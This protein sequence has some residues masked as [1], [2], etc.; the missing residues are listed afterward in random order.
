M[1]PQL[2]CSYFTLLLNDTSAA[3]VAVMVCTVFTGF[4]TAAASAWMR[5]KWQVRKDME[6]KVW[7][8]RA[9]GSLL[10]CCFSGT[11]FFFLCGLP[12]SET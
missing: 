3:A 12:A 11:L 4:L 10:Q 9:E 5:N 1:K 8:G 2:S 7:S 6:E